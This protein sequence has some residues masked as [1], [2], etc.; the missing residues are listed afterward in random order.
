MQCIDLP[1]KVYSRLLY[2]NKYKIS[3]IIVN[4]IDKCNYNC[5]Y[6]YNKKPGKLRTDVHLNL[7]KLFD[8]IKWFSLNINK[9]IIIFILGGEPTLHPDLFKFCINIR[10]NFSTV[11][12]RIVTN[13]SYDYKKMLQLLDYGIQFNLSWHSLSNDLQNINFIKKIEKIPKKFF[14]S[15]QIEIVTMY[16]KLNYEYSLNVFDYFYKK[17][18]KHITLTIVENNH[19]NG[20]FN[21]IYEYTEK[22]NIEYYS[23]IETDDYINN[24]LHNSLTYEFDNYKKQYVTQQI[25]FNKKLAIFKNYICYAG[26]DQIYIHFNGDIA[27]CDDLYEKNI[28]LGNIYNN[29]TFNK[30]KFHYRICQINSCPC[31]FFSKKQKI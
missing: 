23:R 10:K 24:H 21:E 28:L 7:S 6:C 4:I 3:A 8:F 20:Q 14:D 29:K 9:H 15:Y 27:P 31:P 2:S 1:K 19:L 11:N 13:F 18:P 30:S 17:I 16:E 12:C 5:Y 25:Y 26:I 22:Q